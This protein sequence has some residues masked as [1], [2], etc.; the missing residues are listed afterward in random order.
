VTIR[1]ATLADAA[2]ISTLITPLAEK[3]IAYEFTDE[4]RR[5]LLRSMTPDAIRGYIAKGFR[6]HVA[7][8]SDD[9]VGVVATRDDSHLY[10]LFVAE[11][12]QGRGLARKLWQVARQ[13]CLEARNPGEVTVKPSRFAT[14]FYAKLGFRREAEDTHAGVVA[15]TMRF[16]EQAA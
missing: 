6:Y 13:A 9:I 12:S 16:C 5:R 11:R 4:G 7:Q 1:P 10:H 8:E 2:A 3:Y 15:I 14:G